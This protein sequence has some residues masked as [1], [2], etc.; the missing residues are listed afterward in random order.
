MNP[1]PIAN[2]LFYFLFT[3]SSIIIIV[4]FGVVESKSLIDPN[5]TATNNETAKQANHL[6]PGK[7]E[8][9]QEAARGYSQSSVGEKV[10]KLRRLC[11]GSCGNNFLELRSSSTAAFPELKLSKVGE[12]VQSSSPSES[13][14]AEQ[15]ALTESRQQ[16]L[17]VEGSLS[18]KAKL[19]HALLSL[20]NPAFLGGDIL[21]KVG[22]GQNSVAD[23][24][25]QSGRRRLMKFARSALVDRASLWP[26]GVIFYE[27]DEPVDK[28]L[29]ELLSE[30]IQQFHEETCIRFVPRRNNEPDY[31]RIGALNGCFSFIGRIGGEQ[32]LSLGDGCDF[33]GTVTHELLHAV[34]FYHHQNRSDR[35][36]F[37]EILWD[38]IARGKE[39]Q[40][41]KMA[42]EENTLLSEFDYNSIML[43]GPRTFAKTFDRHTMKPK[44]DGVVLLEVVK[45]PGLS[46]LD[47]ESVNKLYKCF[48][49]N[50]ER[51]K[52]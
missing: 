1:I 11:V 12:Q 37:L 26:G 42:P 34:G 24:Q 32:I 18:S 27:L 30:V 10:R 47:I 38:N 16:L 20:Q 40:F 31:L 51:K 15:E 22:G 23:G 49:L 9:F 33:R 5:E 21:V 45:K 46:R 3:L 25:Q 7:L 17:E 4:E 36:E 2:C 52:K 48:E 19:R 8:K 6:P 39:S 35:D 28:N 50:S 43:Y 29:R 44:R 14:A 13:S 41:S